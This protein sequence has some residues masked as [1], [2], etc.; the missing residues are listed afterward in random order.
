MDSSDP[1]VSSGRVKE[2]LVFIFFKFEPLYL[3]VVGSGMEEEVNLGPVVIASLVFQ[4]SLK[5]E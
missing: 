1:L 5:D 3:S 2:D 4:V